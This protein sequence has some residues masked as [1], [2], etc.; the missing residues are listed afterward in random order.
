MFRFNAGSLCNHHKV[1]YARCLLLSDKL[2][3]VT[4]RSNF[5]SPPP[6]SPPSCHSDPQGW[7]LPLLIPPQHFSVHLHPLSVRK[8]TYP[9]L[10][11]LPL[12]S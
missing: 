2:L 4:Q 5:P 11:L 3:T 10:S 6:L 7:T 1:V 8:Y 9:P 12:P